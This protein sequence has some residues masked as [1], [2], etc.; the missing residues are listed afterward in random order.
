MVWWR[1]SS[2]LIDP[3]TA[4]RRHCWKC[5]QTFMPPSTARKWPFSVYLTW[6]LHLTAFTTFF[7][8]GYALSLVLTDLLSTGWGRFCSDVHYTTG[9]LPRA[10]VCHTATAVW[11]PSRVRSGPHTVLALH[12]IMSY[13]TLLP[14]VD[15]LPIHMPTTL[16]STSAS[17]S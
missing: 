13:S 8:V 12:I 6:V 1:S 15:S 17:K 2:K 16:T 3:I 11:C 5:C 14:T 10:L 9:I 7:F 4:Q